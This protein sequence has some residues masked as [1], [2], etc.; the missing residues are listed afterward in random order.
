[1]SMQYIIDSERL[2]HHQQ[3]LLDHSNDP[4]SKRGL[5]LKEFM[6]LLPKTLRASKM[7]RSHTDPIAD[8]LR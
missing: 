1:M 4:S 2:C 3:D 7:E 5:T 6:K 8:L